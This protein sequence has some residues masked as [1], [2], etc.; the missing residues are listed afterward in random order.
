MSVNIS[1]IKNDNFSYKLEKP[2]K[3]SK[4]YPEF[5]N[6]NLKNASS[7][8]MVFDGVRALLTSL[9]GDNFFS[10]LINL[11]ETVVIKPNLIKESMATDQ[12]QWQH[13]ISH[14]SVIRA[15]CD[16]VCLALEGKGKVIICDAP[17]TDSSFQAIAEKNG[18]YAIAEECSRWS[19]IDVSVL[20]LR[21]EEWKSEG[22]VI[23]ERK[24]LSGDPA[25]TIAFNL[26]E[27]SEFYGYKG[28]GRYYGADYDDK[29]VNSHHQGK[30]QE[31]LI[32]ATPIK[33]DVFINIAKLKT[34]KKTGVTLT[35]KNLVGINADKNWLP[36][37][38]EGSPEN[39]GDQFPD[40]SLKREIENRCVHIARKIALKVPIVGP[41]ITKRLRSAGKKVFGN[42]QNTIRSGNWFGNDTTWRMV[43]DL[44]KCLFYGNPD[45]S[46]NLNKKKRFFGII[47]GIIGMEG[48]GPME[49]EPVYSNVLLGGAD[50]ACLDAVGAWLMGFDWKKIPVIKKAFELERYK[51]TDKKPHDIR[52]ISN[53]KDWEGNF[54]DSQDTETFN[55]KPHFGWIGHIERK[56]GK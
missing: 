25:G 36:H 12:S 14:G 34:H 22:E 13:V 55:F 7:E 50:A 5:S 51:I 10:G 15:V 41:V 23:V 26:S 32:C 24:K 6:Y 37:H 16:Y 31:Y 40:L 47:D 29:I 19:G 33:V 1:I 8:N 48:A 35:L 17:Q 39:G 20:D 18:L 21:N 54:L 49:G 3:P 45:S 43:L 46:F 38:T 27:N 4:D 56:K 2:F 9:Y 28:E 53:E 52:I 30:R 44:N 11:G 42:G